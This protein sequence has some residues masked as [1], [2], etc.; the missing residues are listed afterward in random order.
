M[1]ATSP[2]AV[3]TYRWPLALIITMIMLFVTYTA[4][5]AISEAYYSDGFPEALA[6]KVE[7]LPLIFPIHMVAGGLSLL[8]VPAT[9]F[10]R[11]TKFHRISGRIAA[12][13][14]LLAGITAPFVAW[15]VP[16]TIISAAGFTSQS[17]LWVGLLIAGI[18]NI[19]NDRVHA[20][21]TCMLL[22]A[23]VT[24]GALFF[25]VFLALFA[26]L[27]DHHYFNDFYAFNAWFAWGIPLLAILVFHRLRGKKGARPT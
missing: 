3:A 16:V 9:I 13:D 18:W 1:K 25:R 6:V 15:T 27:G 17:I 24:S 11:R 5:R 19:R 23:A 21:Q 26:R 7:L 14:I 12:A 2:T 20:H 8:L 22:M 10:L 4:I